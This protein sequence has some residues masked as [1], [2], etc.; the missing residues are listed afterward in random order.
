MNPELWKITETFCG[1]DLLNLGA[2]PRQ[3]F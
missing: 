3:P 1:K 2:G